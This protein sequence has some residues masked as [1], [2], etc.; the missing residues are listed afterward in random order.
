MNISNDIKKILKNKI[1]DILNF[2]DE[3][4][5]L[6]SKK[7]KLKYIHNLCNQLENEISENI[8]ENNELTIPLKSIKPTKLIQYCGFSNNL[9]K[10]LYVQ[11]KKCILDYTF[12]FRKKYVNLIKKIYYS[13][14]NLPKTEY[15][16]I[17][18]DLN[19]I[20]YEFINKNNVDIINLLKSLIGSNLDKLFIETNIFDENENIKNYYKV[21]YDKNNIEIF[22]HN[23]KITL[24]L[25]YKNLKIT[26]NISVIYQIKLTNIF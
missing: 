18:F 25:I 3:K 14:N 15:D 11:F 17:L 20:V 22:F 19:K 16:E 24:T 10:E 6:L 4:W 23:I 26:N 5:N 1:I 8:V 21:I 9:N 12:A 7:I 2:D 13:Y